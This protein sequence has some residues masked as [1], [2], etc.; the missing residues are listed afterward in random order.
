MTWMLAK[1]QV[2]QSYPERLLGLQWSAP[3]WSSCGDDV[4]AHGRDVHVRV[5]GEPPIECEKPVYE[6][7][8]CR[9][10]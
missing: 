5:D 8:Q 3:A 2:P 1:S 6:L 7:N 9:N 4:H 10:K